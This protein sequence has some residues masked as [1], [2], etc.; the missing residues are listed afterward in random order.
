MAAHHFIVYSNYSLIFGHLSC[1]L[2]S[3]IINNALTHLVTNQCIFVHK[4][5]FEFRIEDWF[6]EVELLGQMV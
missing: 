4:I 6:L 3:T 2:F 1:F 5:L